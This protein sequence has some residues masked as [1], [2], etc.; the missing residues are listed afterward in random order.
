MPLPNP[1][2]DA[3]PFTPLTAEFYDDTIENIE[4]LQDW[5]A[6]D[7]GTLPAELIDSGAIGHSFLEIGRTTLSGAGD[8]ISV[9]SLPA[10]KYLR[11]ELSL[12]NTGALVVGFRFNNDSGANYAYRYLADG[13]AGSS[14]ANTLVA[15]VGSS[16]PMSGCI[17]VMNITSVQ[18]TGQA[19][20]SSGSATAGTAPVYVD[21]WFTWV[22]A[23]DPISRVDIINTGG[24]DFA[25]GSE[26]VVFG[27]N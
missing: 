5:S 12:R 9:A 2:Q 17:E 26:V 18:K 1:G 11:I 16:N 24:G 19:R 27:R 8:T 4:A 20:I 15:S 6:F 3:V 13:T 25:I 22:N 21:F 7:D 10:R 23:T 14:T